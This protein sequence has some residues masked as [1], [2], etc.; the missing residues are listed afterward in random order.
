VLPLDFPTYV[1]IHA[2]SP[3]DPAVVSELFEEYL[4][5][6]GFPKSIN[7]HPDAAEALLDGVISETYRHRRSPQ[8]LK[9]LVS[10]LIERVPSPVSNHALAQEVGISHNT[11]R[12][13]IEFLSDI[14]LV[15]GCI[16]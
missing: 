1:K 13:Y 11:V 14:Y 15:G 10:A 2:A 3:A 7:R 4:K 16:R 6:G 8:L 9:D 5:T 12:D